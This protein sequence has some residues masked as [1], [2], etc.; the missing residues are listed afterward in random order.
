LA[1]AAVTRA[2]YF[3]LV[4][5][6]ATTN[7]GALCCRDHV[8]RLAE[9]PAV[10]LLVCVTG[11]GEQREL[12]R[13]AVE[14]L[15]ADFEFLPFQQPAPADERQPLSRRIAE[16]WPLLYEGT[17]LAQR[18]VDCRFMDLVRAVEPQILLVDYVPSAVFVP[19]AY[20]AAIPRVTITLNR[21]ANFYRELR[22]TR[23]LPGD[24]SDS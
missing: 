23:R 22:R 5:L 3:T 24:A 19:S 12:N 14:A 13:Q 6:F 2:V 4:P 18:Q 21:E 8:R 7:G 10:D 20:S 15:G 16:R 9:D 1:A 11:P 17:A